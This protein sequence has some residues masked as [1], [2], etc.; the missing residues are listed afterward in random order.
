MAV[1]TI[2]KLTIELNP[3]EKSDWFIINYSLPGNTPN[4]VEQQVTSIREGGLS[5]LCGLKKIKPVSNQS[6]GSF[7]LLFDN[8]VDVQEKRLEITSLIRRLYKK[9]P[10]GTSYPLVT[11]KL[12]NKSKKQAALRYAILGQ[13]APA[14]IRGNVE[15]LI[16]KS[17]TDCKHIKLLEINRNNKVFSKRN[18]RKDSN[19]LLARAIII[20]SRVILL[21]AI[22]TCCSLTAFLLNGKLETFWFSI[23]VG[24]IGRLLF[25]LLAIFLILPLFYGGRINHLHRHQKGQIIF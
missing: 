12:T 24:I 2:Q 14:E 6:R 11:E 13:D 23:A 22:S 3:S 20:R 18:F 8:G 15:G 10:E 9:L 5:Q 1:F 16:R 25:S 17:L 7:E 4:T 21:T 19:K